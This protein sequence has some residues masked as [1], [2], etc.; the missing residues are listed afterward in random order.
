MIFVPSG[1]TTAAFSIWRTRARI[2]GSVTPLGDP[3]QQPLMMNSVEKFGQVQ[4]NHRLI[5]VP[6]I[7]RCFGDGGMSAAI[8]AEPVT[9]GVKGRLEDRLQN[10][11][12]GLLNHP[13]HD[14]R[15]A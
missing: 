2:R 5:A 6:Q 1:I 15:N 3:G 4:I 11:E 9:A 14:I 12:H 8:G 13:V 10:L 7:S